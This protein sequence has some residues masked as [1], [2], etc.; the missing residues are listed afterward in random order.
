MK[1]IVKFSIKSYQ[2][3]DDILDIIIHHKEMEEQ[4]SADLILNGINAEV[5]EQAIKELSDLI[6][7]IGEKII[8]MRHE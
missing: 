5:K 4:I 1:D 7:T 6:T 2:V 3:I 8:V